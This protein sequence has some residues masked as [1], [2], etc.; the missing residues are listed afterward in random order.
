MHSFNNSQTISCTTKKC[1]VFSM[2]RETKLFQF[3][4]NKSFHRLK[5]KLE[6]RT[7]GT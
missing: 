2:P 3:D 4:L 1:L 5:M 7:D 6:A